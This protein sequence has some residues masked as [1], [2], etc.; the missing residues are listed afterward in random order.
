MPNQ[1]KNL[2]LRTYNR[3]GFTLIE[4]MVSIAIIT[5]TFF[6]II[7]IFPFSLN[8]N[9]RAQNLTS[10]AY[11]AQAGI[12]KTLSMGYELSGVGAVETKARLSNDPAS[13]LYPF[14]RQTTI[15][16]VDGNLADAVTD[17]GLKKI[18][19]AVF[20]Y[21]PLSAQE[22]QYTLTTLLSKN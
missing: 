13:F 15:T 12:E 14:Y 7:S 22:Q 4:V 5:G 8:M 2:R 11:L 3:R 9:Q 21:N 17:T 20:W 1:Y 16:Y 18:V 19:S 10:A 6:A